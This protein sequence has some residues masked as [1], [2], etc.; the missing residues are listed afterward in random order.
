M[1]L[2]TG[3]K[4]VTIGKDSNAKFATVTAVKNEICT[5]R[6]YMCMW[7]IWE[8]YPIGSTEQKR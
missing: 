7:P 3:D 1:I 2:T 6:M 4:K 5:T 8:C